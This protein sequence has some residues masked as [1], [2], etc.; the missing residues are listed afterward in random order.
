[1]KQKKMDTKFFMQICVIIWFLIV[2]RTNSDDFKQYKKKSNEEN[3]AYSITN[4]PNLSD[5]MYS[6]I[7]KEQKTD[8]KNKNKIN[9][10]NNNNIN[11]NNKDKRRQIQSYQMMPSNLVQPPIQQANLNSIQYPIQNN[12]IP[13]VVHHQF[14]Y[15][16]S[17]GMGGGFPAAYNPPM[18]TQAYNPPN[19]NNPIDG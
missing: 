5:E 15:I 16:Q 17:G 19:N 12:N 9:N 10:N 7:E 6:F 1:M 8:N 14:P 4:E 18:F 13:S 11:N 3:D 2:K